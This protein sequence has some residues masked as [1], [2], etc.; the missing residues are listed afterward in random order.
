MPSKVYMLVIRAHEA[1]SS[2]ISG[3]DKAIQEASFC[4]I[5]EHLQMLLWL[6]FMIPPGVEII[7]LKLLSS[8]LESRQRSSIPLEELIMASAASLPPRNEEDQV[9]VEE[10]SFARIVVLNRPEQ[11][12]A[13]SFYMISR[14]LE[15]FTSYEKD[16][17]VKLTIIKGKG[18]V[19]CA[20]AD[21]VAVA[22]NIKQGEWKLGAEFFW[23]QFA[24]HYLMAT[25]SKPHVVLVH[26]FSLGWALLNTHSYQYCVL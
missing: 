23:K 18:R 17:A 1:F 14:L 10:K 6:D 3:V 20:G 2:A 19:F 4:S 12:N 5:D 7:E 8:F 26:P 24:L 21:V 22:H 16:S 13:V 25:Y 15:L 11:M 9:L